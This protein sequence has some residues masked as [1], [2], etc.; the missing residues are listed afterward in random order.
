METGAIRTT[1]VEI[2][3]TC[4]C[5]AARTQILRRYP[6]TPYHTMRT[7]PGTVLPDPHLAAFAS[8]FQVVPGTSTKHD[9]ACYPSDTGYLGTR[10]SF[11]KIF[12]RSSLAM[13]GEWMAIRLGRDAHE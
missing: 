7:A 6:I 9:V 11:K 5:R 3:G 12:Q 2:T 10:P 1:N 13:I 8:C 4:I